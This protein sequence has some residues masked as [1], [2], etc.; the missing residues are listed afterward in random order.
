MKK[1]QI[2]E[3]GI[4][5]IEVYLNIIN[6]DVLINNQNFLMEGH[7]YK[8]Q[9]QTISMLKMFENGD[10]GEISQIYADFGCTP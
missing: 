2:L 10:I 3:F 8:Y 7:P 5:D 9:P 1:R 6:Y 4:F